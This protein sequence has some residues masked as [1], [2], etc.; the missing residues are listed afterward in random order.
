MLA[1]AVRMVVGHLSLDLD[2]LD[3]PWVGISL[4]SEWL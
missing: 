2:L 3:L 1:V 4:L